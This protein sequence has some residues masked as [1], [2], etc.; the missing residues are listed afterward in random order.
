MT[1]VSFPEDACPLWRSE[2]DIFYKNSKVFA[3]S[4]RA[5]NPLPQG[6]SVGEFGKNLTPSKR[7]VCWDSQ[8]KFSS[9]VRKWQPNMASSRESVVHFRM[10][11]TYEVL[12]SW[13][14]EVLESW[15]CE[16]LESW[17]CEAPKSRIYEAL[18]SWK[19]EDLES[20]TCE[21]PESGICEI[22]ESSE[23]QVRRLWCMKIFTH[24]RFGSQ[25]EAKSKTLPQKSGL[26]MWT[27]GR[28][29][30][31]WNYPR[32]SRDVKGIH[33]HVHTGNIP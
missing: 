21:A 13:T 27:S 29:V 33:V 10:I 22:R 18:E 24:K 2:G 15:I 7:R 20:W 14:C 19:C 1:I 26:N 3:E 4:D 6:A 17:T 23:V 30:Y 11:E 28:L 25:Q 16:D 9:N 8:N 32:K 12:E 31:V 5:V